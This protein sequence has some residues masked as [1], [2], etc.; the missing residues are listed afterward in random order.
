MHILN[1]RRQSR[2]SQHVPGSITRA[3]QNEGRN[4]ILVDVC[5]KNVKAAAV[6]LEAA[7]SKRDMKLPNSHS[8]M[9]TNYHPSEDVSNKLN[10]QG[11]QAYQEL[12]GDLR[13]EV[14]IGRVDIFLEVALLSSHLALPLS[15]HLQ[16]SISD[17]WIHE[18]SPKT[19]IILRSSVSVYQQK[20][21]PQ[22]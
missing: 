13:W 7:L 15:G 18:A 4:Q 8:P 21:I 1:K 10:N 22:I 14:E 12:I 17:I 6:N 2:A 9:P 20:P 19:E 5:E 11:I 3:S 16:S